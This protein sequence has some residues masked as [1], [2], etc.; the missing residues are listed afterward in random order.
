MNWSEESRRCPPAGGPVQAPDR[1][2]GEIG[3]VAAGAVDP[4]PLDGKGGKT[5]PAVAV[6]QLKLG[7]RDCP[8][9]E[10]AL[11]PLPRGV[12]DKAYPLFQRR[13]P[14]PGQKGRHR[15]GRAEEGG[16]LFHGGRSIR[17]GGGSGRPT[18]AGKG[19]DESDGESEGEGETAGQGQQT[20]PLGGGGARSLH[21]GALL[22]FADGGMGVLPL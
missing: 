15:G 17:Q 4:V 10:G 7:R 13:L 3:V 19:K 21:W 20:G 6:A 9:G 8:V 16:Y 12:A 14:G 18:A 2:L 22:S 5:V 1:R 11:P